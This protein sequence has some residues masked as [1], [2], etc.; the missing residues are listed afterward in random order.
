MDV[1]QRVVRTLLRI[2]VRVSATGPRL[3]RLGLGP[4]EDLSAPE[5]SGG[6]RPH[7]GLGGRLL[8]GG[9]RLCLGGVPSGCLVRKSVVSAP[10]TFHKA[11]CCGS[12]FGIKRPSGMLFISQESGKRIQ[13]SAIERLH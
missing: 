6:Q 8:I 1:R 3:G 7:P 5:V 11:L 10:L 2:S 13:N 9:A 4:G 12:N